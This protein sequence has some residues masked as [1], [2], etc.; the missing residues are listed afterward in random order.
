MEGYNLLI[1][2]TTLIILGYTLLF[3]IRFFSFKYFPVNSM[4]NRKISVIIPARNEEKVIYE[5]LDNL[6]KNN[7]KDIKEIIITID[8]GEDNTSNI[9]KIFAKKDNRIK[10]IKIDNGSPSKVRAILKAIDYVKGEYCAM[11]D[12]DTMLKKG[13][14][15]K[16]YNLLRKEDADMITGIIDPYEDGGLECKIISWDRIFRQRFLQAAKSS[17]GMANFPGCFFIV[18]KEKYKSWIKDRILEDYYLT[19]QGFR[20]NSNIKFIPEIVAHEKERKNFRGL[21]FQR[22]RWTIG[23]IRLTKEFLNTLK[24]I[25]ISKKIILI[26]YPLFWYFF[27]YYMTLL[28]FLSIYFKTNL[29][30]LN[31]ILLFLVNYILMLCLKVRYKDLKKIDIMTSFFFLLIFP[32][33]ISLTFIYSLFEITFNKNGVNKIFTQK[34]YFQR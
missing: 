6:I 27:Y 33:I 24:K 4:N 34:R 1:N 28:L 3:A 12:A 23:N 8:N 19:L 20:K 9:C 17:F 18:K 7:G 11:L 2:V 31:Y 29:F 15:K 16:L 26:S 25:P 14:I 5:C 13:S 22:V 10:I 21:F 32:I 30:I